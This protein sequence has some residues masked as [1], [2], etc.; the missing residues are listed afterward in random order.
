MLQQLLFLRLG[1]EVTVD[2]NSGPDCQCR[3][4]PKKLLVL[5]EPK[6]SDRREIQIPIVGNEPSISIVNELV[7]PSSNNR[8]ISNLQ[9]A[10]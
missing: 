1:K 3:L 2:T 6:T 8:Y 4:R 5:Q 7:Y 10:R 9:L